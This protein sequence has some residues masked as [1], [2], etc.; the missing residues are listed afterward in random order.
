MVGSFVFGRRLQAEVREAES[1]VQEY[2][3]TTRHQH[4]S[5]HNMLLRHDPLHDGIEISNGAAGRQ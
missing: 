1:F 5:P 4:R 3:A 2:A